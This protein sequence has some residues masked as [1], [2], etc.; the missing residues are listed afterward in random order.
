MSCIPGKSSAQVVSSSA[1][2]E[3]R[4]V[5]LKLSEPAYPP[6]ARAARI[7]G[8]VSVTLGIRP[9]GSVESAV[10]VSG[11]PLLGLAALDSARQSRFE[12]RACPSARNSYSLK[13]KFELVSPDVTKDCATLTDEELHE[14]S[15]KVNL[16]QH[17]I[18]VLALPVVICD[19]AGEIRKVRSAKCLYLWR[20]GSR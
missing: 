12:C 5:L 4:V 2:V 6:I 13:Y 9:D 7:Q 14:H 3:D 20:C 16:S 18:T 11:H 8:D 19:P 15:A 17:E 1:T 10:I